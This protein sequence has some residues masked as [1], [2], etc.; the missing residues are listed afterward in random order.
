MN[1]TYQ[2]KTHN[3]E[4]ILLI[5]V[6]N[7]SS[8]YE[9]YDGLFISMN[10]SGKVIDKIEIENLPDLKIIGHS[11]GFGGILTEIGQ[12]CNLKIMVICEI[13]NKEEQ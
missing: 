3:G 4:N 2:Y 13:L 5:A 9:Y 11:I 1:S 8:R 6:S 7:K 12:D 10:E